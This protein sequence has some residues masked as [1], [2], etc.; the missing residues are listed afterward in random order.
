MFANLWFA[1]PPQ[2]GLG[3]FFIYGTAMDLRRTVFRQRMYTAWV[4]YTRRYAPLYFAV[5]G[6]GNTKFKRITGRLVMALSIGENVKEKKRY[7]FLDILKAIGIYFVVIYH[8][9]NLSSNILEN[10]NITNYFN[11]F[12]KS[13]FSTCVPVF[14]FVN[15]FLLLNKPFDLKK[16]I[17]KTIRILVISIIWQ[18]I[19]VFVLMMIRKE[20]FSIIEIVKIVATLRLK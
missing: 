11:Y 12:I 18:F 3:S 14:F 13:I 8:F 4:S 10:N 2:A 6:K 1:I 5:T 19:T 20:Y 16:H 9:N 15:G 7:D 17:T